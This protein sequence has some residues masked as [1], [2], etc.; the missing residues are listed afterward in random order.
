M[1]KR[2]YSKPSVKKTEYMEVTL[3]S[4]SPGGGGGGGGNEGNNDIFI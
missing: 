1:K 4:D 3:L 2:E